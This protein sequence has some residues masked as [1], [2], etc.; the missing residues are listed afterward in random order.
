MLP[1][2][3]AIAPVASII[4]I[5]LTGQRVPIVRGSYIVHTSSIGAGLLECEM[6][7]L[8]EAWYLILRHGRNDYLG[9]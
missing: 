1:I 7:I 3:N 2:A 6:A 5:Y 8:C 4:D 9:T